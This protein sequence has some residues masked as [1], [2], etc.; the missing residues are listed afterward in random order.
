M[1]TLE[2]AT[3]YLKKSNTKPELR[4]AYKLMAGIHERAS[5]PN[6]ALENFK[7]YAALNDTLVK[8]EA[9]QRL[10]ELRAQ[11]KIAQKEQE[12]K[13]LEDKQRQDRIIRFLLLFALCLALGTTFFIYQANAKRKKAY[14]ALMIEKKKAEQLYQDL[15]KAQ[16]QLIQ[17]EKMASLGQFTAGIAHE[18]N[19]PINY[20]NANSEALQLDL[21]DL[22]K[23]LTAFLQLKKDAE[24]SAEVNSLITQANEIDIPF[25]STEIT[26][27]VA[28]IKEGVERVAEI[29][30]G[31]K[32]FTHQSKGVFN[33]EDLHLIL[34]SSLVILKNKINTKD[35]NVTIDAQVVSD[36]FCQ[37]GKISQVFVNVIDNAIEAMDVNG[38]LKIKL[39]ALK[40][41]AI[42]EIKDNGT[43]IKEGTLK[44][45]FDPFYTTKEVGKG[46]GLG[47]AIS[48]GIIK[49]HNGE[50]SV[51]SIVGKGTSVR[52]ALPFKQTEI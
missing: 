38:L 46:T 40:N 43:G 9:T 27:L 5:N 18:I 1:Q 34:K 32:T 19:N 16:Q 4:D 52:I 23:F 20:I 11:N 33:A 45:V 48:Y 17:S 12:I 28:G 36:V 10:A 39:F 29:V 7:N 3:T 21:E 24:N 26:E 30:D 47:M 25:L 2:K 13:L 22:Q 31:L 8:T 42:V 37:A 50:I 35:I 49:D 14:T 15:Q 6:K 51:E 44:H 41:Q